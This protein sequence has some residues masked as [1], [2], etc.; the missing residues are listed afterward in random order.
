MFTFEF[1]KRNAF[2]VEFTLNSSVHSNLKV[3]SYETILE[4]NTRNSL[5]SMIN[6]WF[7]R[8]CWEAGIFL[9]FFLNGDSFVITITVSLT[10]NPGNKM[11]KHEP[12]KNC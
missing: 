11:I 5:S 1:F 9:F 4:I 6:H 10:M 2:Y 3:L 7:N 8:H 12:I